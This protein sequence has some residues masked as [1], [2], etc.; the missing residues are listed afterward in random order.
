MCC[1]SKGKGDGLF[2]SFQSHLEPFRLLSVPRL[3]WL[4]VISQTLSCFR[5]LAVFADLFAWNTAHLAGSALSFG[6]ELLAFPQ[7]DLSEH[8]I[9]D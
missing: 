6:P 1:S 2:L 8:P 7:R 4:L 9:L 3:H 5:A